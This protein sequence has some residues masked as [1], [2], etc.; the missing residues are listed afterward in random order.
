MAERSTRPPRYPIKA[1]SQLT[2]IGIDTLRAWE[3]RYAA[4]SPARDRRGRLYTDSDITHLRLL[5][6]AVSAGHA[7]GRLARLSDDELRLLVEG[8][9]DR[10]RALTVARTVAL[11]PARVDATLLAFDSDAL[12]QELWRIA[13]AVPPID[14]VRDVLLPALARVGD[15]WN[16]EQAGIAHEH[17]ISATLRNL[18]GS[19]LRLYGRGQ[20]SPRLLFATPS[21]E[22]HEIGVLSAAMLAA[23]HGL[24]VT[25]LGPELPA[26]AMI[27]AVKASGARVLVLGLTLPGTFQPRDRELKRIVRGLPSDVALWT[28]GAGTGEYRTLLAERGQVFVDLDAYVGQL[29][30]LGR[31]LN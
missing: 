25:Y 4:V 27:A 28:G 22:R 3:R 2:G 19:F 21:G 9:A 14:L 29:S 16:E 1:V 13:A 5:H 17:L 24:A 10:D 12:E 15:R 7:V 23:S 30:R 20:S 6:R 18:L 26:P 11:D 8:N 31:A